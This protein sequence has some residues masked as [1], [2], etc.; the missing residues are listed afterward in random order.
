MTVDVLHLVV[1]FPDVTNVKR[2]RLEFFG[3]H[4][5]PTGKHLLFS[6]KDNL[7]NLEIHE[8]TEC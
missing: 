3:P 2:V 4:L 5:R 6:E 7:K 8:L 1:V